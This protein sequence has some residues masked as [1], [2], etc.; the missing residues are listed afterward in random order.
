[1]LEGIIGYIPK[2]DLLI[3]ELTVFQNLYFNAKLCFKDF[4]NKQI[5]DL[6][7]RVLVDLDLYDIKD[8]KVGNPLKRFISGGQRKRLNIGL[9]LIREP[10]ILFID[11]PT[12]GL[13]STDSEMVMDLL[14]KQAQKDKLLIVNIHQPSSDIFK[15][16]DKLLVLDKGGRVVYYGDP[17]DAVVYFKTS[18]QLINAEDS[19][20]LTCG[21]VNPEQVL[22]ILEA[23]RVNENGEFAKERIV[24]ADEWYKL[25]KKKIEAAEGFVKRLRSKCYA[26]DNLCFCADAVDIMCTR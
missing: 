10:Y 15:L 24:T 9:E 1:M 11:E 7:N 13:S 2:E 3:E 17:L 16:F 4:L 22:Q 12:S 18:N 21:N 26:I 5:T 19:E 25:Y 8:L 20:C 14:R 23:K 6:V